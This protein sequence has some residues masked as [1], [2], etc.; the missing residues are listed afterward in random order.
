MGTQDKTH[1]HR[2]SE[3]ETRTHGIGK[4]QRNRK[5]YTKIQG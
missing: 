5:N 3:M 1:I 2:C 4:N